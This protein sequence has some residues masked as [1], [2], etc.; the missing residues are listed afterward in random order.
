MRIVTRPDFDGIVC[1]VLLFDVLDITEPI[2]WIEPYELEKARDEIRDGDV[3]ANLLYVD[4]C[5]LWFD[6]HISNKI[7]APF[8]GV[9]DIAPSAAGVIFTYYKGKFSRDFE[10]LVR[11]A[12]KIDSASF[13]KDE[14]LNPYSNP[15]SMLSSTISGKD[16]SDE[17]YWNRIVELLGSTKIEKIILD[18]EVQERSDAVIGQDREYRKYIEQYSHDKGSVVVTDFRPLEQEPKGNRFI[19]YSLFPETLVDMKVR[20]HKEKRDKVI[21]SLGRNIFNRTCNVNLGA[22]VAQY[23]GGGHAGAGSCSFHVEGADEKILEMID[24][25]LKNECID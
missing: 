5:S 16:K 15:Y 7:D 8:V 12:D 17:S 25:L 2:R 1:A 10:E 4:T 23:G 24:I 3:I 18:N 6:H 13:T 22:L 21:V 20:L 9:F 19:V 11:Q 14:I